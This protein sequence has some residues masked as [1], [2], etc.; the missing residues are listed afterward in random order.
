M[1][2]FAAAMPCNPLGR[3]AQNDKVAVIIKWQS[4]FS[5]S[6]IASRF[7]K[8][9]VA[10]QIRL[11][12][13]PKFKAKIKKDEMLW[14]SKSNVTKKC[15]QTLARPALYRHSFHRDLDLA[16][17]SLLG[18]V[19]KGL[20]SLLFWAFVKISNCYFK[21]FLKGNQ[22]ACKH[23][24]KQKYILSFWA[25]VKGYPATCKAQPQQ[26]NPL[27]MTAHFIILSFRTRRNIH[28]NSVSTLCFQQSVLC[29][30]LTTS[31][32]NTAP[33]R[34]SA[35]RISWSPCFYRL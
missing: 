35:F 18:W 28:T 1:D 31:L 15:A 10:I 34:S 25:F 11:E 19:C 5:L 8:N 12:F 6:V 4:A 7:H 27:A 17:Q 9:G 24:P 33:H 16:I 13:C 14:N 29:S 3:Y 21:P 30:L 32:R 22:M 23:K 20:S 2:F 26:K